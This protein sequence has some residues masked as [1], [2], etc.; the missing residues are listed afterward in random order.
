MSEH[1]AVAKLGDRGPS[2]PRRAQRSV[3]DPLLLA[4]ARYVQAL[5][6]RYPEGPDQMRGGGLDASANMPTVTP[7]R[8]PAR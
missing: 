5:D 2:K 1:G 6:E 8:G 4:L 7:A 3:T